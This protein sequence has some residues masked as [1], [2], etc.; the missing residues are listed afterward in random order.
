MTGNKKATKLSK[1]GMR[2][3]AIIV[4]AV[5]ILTAAAIA[6]FVWEFMLASRLSEGRDFETLLETKVR[7]NPQAMSALNPQ[8]VNTV[9]IPGA[10]S[11]LA[12]AELQRLLVD[13]AE[14]HG[15]VVERTRP[16]PI[17]NREG[18]ASVRMEV[19]ASGSI[20]S[21]RGYIHGIE[22]GAPLIFVNQVHIA[23]GPTV[24]DGDVSDNLSV[25]LEVEVFA[26][27][28]KAS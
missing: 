7:A 1:E 25:R 27:W 16:L 8:T 9:F 12:A 13:S 3:L 19:N 24:P 14:K 21:L 17:E 6:P 15:M 23:A 28:E 2:G 5:L 18:L 22:T 20:E 11:G 4:G 26:W 10:T